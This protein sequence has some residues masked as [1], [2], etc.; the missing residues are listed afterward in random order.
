MTFD[1]LQTVPDAEWLIEDIL[2]AGAVSVLWGPSGGGKSFV[3]HDWAMS[4]ATGKPLWFGHKVR[5]GKV[6][7]IF[8]EGKPGYKKRANAWVAHHKRDP[9]DGDMIW[10]SQM[11]NII[12][13]LTYEATKQVIR[14]EQPDLVIIDTFARAMA[15]YSENDTTE[16]GR[17]VSAA[18][19]LRD[20]FDCAVLLVHHPNQSMT[21]P[22]KM[23]GNGA[24]KGAIDAEY[25]LDVP[26]PD[27]PA[28][29]RVLYCRKM[30]DSGQFSPIQIFLKP[31]A[32]SL[33]PSEYPVRVF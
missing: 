1:Q 14:E 13:P 3:V 30:K 8:G 7:Y 11:V 20:E 10:M 22:K 12:D 15:G 28:S 4:I 24:L 17:F 19:G 33:V 25:E 26:E 23:R 2:L 27:D 5:K 16:M 18:E 9:E 29:N 32:E 6:L 21:G 31:V